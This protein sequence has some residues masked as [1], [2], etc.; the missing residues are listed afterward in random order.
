MELAFTQGKL[1]SLINEATSI[2]EEKTEFFYRVSF[3]I[4]S[5]FYSYEYDDLY[6]EYYSIDGLE[7]FYSNQEAQFCVEV[8]GLIKERLSSLT[9]DP[10]E[11]LLCLF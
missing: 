11:E 3:R 1:K 4:G 7:L 2:R 8:K 9:N 6:T 10:I 5:K